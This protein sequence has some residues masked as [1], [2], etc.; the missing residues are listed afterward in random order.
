MRKKL[1]IAIDSSIHSQH[2]LDYAIQLNCCVKEIDFVLFN[3]QPFIS[4]YLIEEVSKRQKSKDELEKVYEGNHI[5]SKK[6]LENCK[7]RMVRKGVESSCIEIKTQPRLNGIAKDILEAA[8]MG[9]YDAII[10]GRRGIGGLQELF[11]GSVTSNLLAST[12]YIPIWVVDGQV[13][14]EKVLIAVDGSPTSLRAV[15]H[16][17]FIFSENRKV[18]LEF[19]NIKTR[20]GDICEIDTKTQEI[21]ELD[22]A[23]LISNKKC[24][25]DF[26][27]T[28]RGILN[29]AGIEQNQI[30]FRSEKK[31]FFTG[32]A[33]I[34]VQ[35]KEKFGTVII[36]K[37]G[38]G[39]NQHLGSVASHIVQKLSDC[40]VWVVP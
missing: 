16:L 1:L 19:L 14:S 2:A 20:L 18:R 35:K 32:K 24:I 30:V 31:K 6:L 8:E 11:V 10:V 38:A 15:D 26:S 3:I 22:K 29:K 23:I 17:S 34:E 27:A 33:I 7:A 21:A 36:G 37:I 5:A 25:S 9:S 13:E 40:A 4:Q 12:Y 28:A 39:R